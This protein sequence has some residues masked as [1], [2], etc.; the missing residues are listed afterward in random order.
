[1]TTNTWNK[2]SYNVPTLT[3]SSTHTYA[4]PP[5]LLGTQPPSERAT[6]LADSHHLVQQTRHPG[7]VILAR[8]GNERRA[9]L[10]R[11]TPLVGEPYHLFGTLRRVHAR[12]PV[13]HVVPQFGEAMVAHGPAIIV[14]DLD[15]VSTRTPRSG[16]TRDHCRAHA[17]LVR[18]A[19]HH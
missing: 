6:L 17:A 7:D 16:T 14:P 19:I 18:D 5:L 1:M 3:A 13:R 9:L 10:F 12:A 2:S 8:S 15:D 4:S 11:T